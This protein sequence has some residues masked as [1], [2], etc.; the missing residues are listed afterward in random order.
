MKSRNWNRFAVAAGRLFVLV[1][2]AIAC[3]KLNAQAPARFVGTVTAINGNTITV[4]S[5]AGDSKDVAVPATAII[6]RLEPGQKDLSA[7]ATIQLTD[8]AA[9]D[10]VLVK[11]DP[12]SATP[13][14]LQIVA[15]KKTDIAQRQQKEQ[16]EWQRNGTGGL[17]KSVDPAS[18]VVLLTTGAGPTAKTVTVHIGKD[19]VLKRYASTSVRFADAQP[20]PLD[21]IHPGDQFQVLGQKNADGTEITAAQ[22][23]SGSFRNVSG[24]VTAIDTSA[25]TLTV[26][27]L[28]TKK[29]VTVHITADADV[30]R[31]PAGHDGE[32]DCGPFEGRRRA[33][34]RRHNGGA[35]QGG[36]AQSANGQNG[37]MGAG[38][39]RRAGGGMSQALDRA[40]AVQLGDLKKGDAVMLVSTEGA[41]DVTAI[42]LLAGV[43]ARCL[44]LT[45]PA[46]CSPTGAWVREAAKK[47]VHNSLTCNQQELSEEYV[48]SRH[49]CFFHVVHF[50]VA[51]AFGLASLAARAQ[52]APAATGT[53]HG[54]IAD[55]TGA[56]IP[57]AKVTVT[58]TG[59]KTVGTATADASGAYEITGLAAASYI[60][61]S[62]YSGFAAFKSQAIPLAAGQVKRV[63]IAMAIEVE[64]QSI[65][66]TDESTTVNVEA[67]GNA[68]SIV[69]KDKDL[70]ALS[71]DPDELSNEL[72]ALAG[73]SARPNGGQIYI[74]GFSGGQLPP[75]S[76]I[77]EIR[78]NQNPFSAEYDRLGYGRIE[79]LTK[80][81]TDKLHG[82]IFVQGNDKPFNTGNPFTSTI[83]EY[84]SYQF[85]ATLNGSLSKK[86]SFFVSAEQRNTE[87]VNAWRVFN[88]VLDQRAGFVDISNYGVNLLNRRIRDNASAR[89]DLQLG[90]RNTLT[91]RYGFWSES[92][93]GDLNNLSLPSASTHESNTDHTV[94]LSDSFILSDH[95]VNETRF[96]FERQ[97][98]NHYPDSTDRTI[99][100]QGD[101]TGGGYNGQ[102]SRDHA[103]RLEFW[104]IT[105]IS[106]GAH[107]IK[108]GTRMRDTRDANLTT[109]NFNGSFTFG[110]YQQYQAMANGLLNGDSFDQLVSMGNGPISAEYTAGN[111]STVANMFDIALFAQDDWKVNPRLSLSGGLRWEAQNH[112]SD[113]ND[114][115]PRVSMAYHA[116]DGGTKNKKTK[117]VLRSWLR[118]C[119]TIACRTNS[120]LTVKNRSGTC[121]NR[122][123]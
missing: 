89:F 38:Q 121:R 116:L 73:P 79:I 43:E 52:S 57:G 75:K 27:D 109:A 15:M 77:R 11:L 119:S 96:Q 35:A 2:L 78:I 74:D 87:N 104:N 8:L 63:D 26:K 1:A 17:V 32:D 102:V 118:V 115:A 98:E 86:A 9:G 29:S 111:E 72:T 66:V 55:Q 108:F 120:L 14:A 39:G 21:A 71:D 88:A 114:W 41:N 44:K 19:A 60:V 13:Q 53:I 93:H 34:R 81:G 48:Y 7:A 46:T 62:D 54:H 103:T 110:N 58:T 16:E 69:L 23:V 117:T 105:T 90:A 68:N 107:A 91:A 123:S 85:N 18:S 33:G 51:L 82:Q 94:Q 95:A 49:H 25:S 10:R 42:K 22:V 97:N 24:L 99:F 122:S 59:G 101:F 40:P 30:P 112:I 100:V 5:D 12:N 31:Q 70:D 65:V 64:Q 67:A 45:L 28:A 56:L 113:H 106:H 6:K 84:Y 50:L 4:K 20:A 37:G 36:G 76:A 3:N 47:P 80:P 92:E 83:P 61:N